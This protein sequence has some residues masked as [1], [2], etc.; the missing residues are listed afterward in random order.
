M[1]QHCLL[2]QACI[3][4]R[5]TQLAENISTIFRRKMRVRE[6]PSI[7]REFQKFS[8]Q[9]EFISSLYTYNN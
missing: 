7:I 6:G 9:L 3:L 2:T 4:H 8:L 5:A 1:M